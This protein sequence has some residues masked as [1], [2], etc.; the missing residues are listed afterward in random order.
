MTIVKQAKIY[1][2]R[3]LL[4][5]TCGECTLYTFRILNE[6]QEITCPQC[7]T[8]WNIFQLQEIRKTS[9]QII[10]ELGY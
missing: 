9:D 8:E 3:F 6:K 1:I 10:K 5:C 4:D 2:K 7:L